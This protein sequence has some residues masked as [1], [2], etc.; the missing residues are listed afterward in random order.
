[1]IFKSCALARLAIF[2][3]ISPRPTIPIVLPTSEIPAG[4]G[5]FPDLI[6][7]SIKKAFRA[8]PRI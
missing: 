3:P 2:L 7:R 1:M 8:R 4:F 6:S 5:Q